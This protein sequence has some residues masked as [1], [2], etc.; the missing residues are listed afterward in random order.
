MAGWLGGWVAGW[1]GG[2]EE[3][4]K[5]GNYPKTRPAL[6]V[7]LTTILHIAAEN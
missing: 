4:E 5:S 6:L 7:H 3:R 1:L 2:G